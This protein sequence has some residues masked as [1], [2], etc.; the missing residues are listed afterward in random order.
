L[1]L[2]AAGLFLR[3]LVKLTAIDTGFDKRNVLVFSMDAT[4]ANLP[5]DKEQAQANRLQEQIEQRVQSIPGVQAD[6]FSFFTFNQGG[7]T[8]A[9]LFQGVP[10][11]PG[12]QAEVFFNNVGNGF[13]SA[14]GIPLIEGRTFTPQDTFHSPKVAVINQTMARRFFPNG[15]A[16]GHHFGIGD[17]PGHS[18]DIEVIGVAKDAKHNN[19]AENAEMAA[20]FP[21]SQNPGF[22]GN[23][24]VRYTGDPQAIVTAARRVIADAN[25]NILVDNFTTL[26]AQVDDSIATPTL[27]SRLSAFFGL[28]AVFLACIGIYGLLSY[29]VLRRTNEIGIRLALGAQPQW[30]LWMVLRESML[31]LLLGLAAGLP[32]ALGASRILGNLLYQLS[33]TDPGTYALSAAVIALMTLAAAWLPARR[34]TKVNPMTALRCD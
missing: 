15:S 10:R 14:M 17:D 19:L 7:W 1:L 26:A 25:P 3:S 11:T 16:V 32:I 21:C 33:P 12:N 6:S 28:L 9:T 23:F 34:A 27:I 31:L 22:Y 20:Y 8:D 4:A 13:F 2:T 18:G 29:S 24:L 30:L 5:H